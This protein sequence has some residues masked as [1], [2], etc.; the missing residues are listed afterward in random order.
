MIIRIPL[1]KKQSLFKFV[2]EE[3]FVNIVILA[4]NILSLICKRTHHTVL[5]LDHH[6]ALYFRCYLSETVFPFSDKT[7]YNTRVMDL[8]KGPVQ[9]TSVKTDTELLNKVCSN[10]KHI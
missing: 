1:T 5:C 3:K 9:F 8:L 7:E 10:N 6:R 4:R 2:P